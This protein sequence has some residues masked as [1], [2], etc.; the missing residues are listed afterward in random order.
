MGADMEVRVCELGAHRNCCIVVAVAELV[1]RVNQGRLRFRL[2]FRGV[3]E[4]E[5]WMI[6][7]ALSRNGGF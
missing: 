3:A 1:S 5:F 4:S 2:G 6:R 7:L